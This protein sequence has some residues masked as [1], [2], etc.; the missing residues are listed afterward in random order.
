MPWPIGP[1]HS[2]ILPF[3]LPKVR[4]ERLYSTFSCHSLAEGRLAA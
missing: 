3:F 4:K 1:G 2:S